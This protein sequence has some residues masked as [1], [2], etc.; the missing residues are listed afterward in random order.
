MN[1]RLTEPEELSPAAVELLAAIRDHLNLPLYEDG[2]KAARRRWA[3]LQALRV[4]DVVAALDGL[5]AVTADDARDAAA[6][7]RCF[8]AEVTG[9]YATAEVNR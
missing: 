5:L 4:A 1:T 9:D 7:F 6:A 3:N 2:N 8:A